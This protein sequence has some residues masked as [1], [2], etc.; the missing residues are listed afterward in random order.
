MRTWMGIALTAFLLF[1]LAAAAAA[2]L[3]PP[4]SPAPAPAEPPRRGLLK[5]R[6]RSRWKDVFH[7]F[8]GPQ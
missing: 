5:G 2:A 8:D 1:S 3:A 4:P 7:L 6:L